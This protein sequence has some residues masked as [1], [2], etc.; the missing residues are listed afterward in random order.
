MGGGASLN[1]ENLRRLRGYAKNSIKASKAFFERYARPA[2]TILITAILWHFLGVDKYVNDVYLT[3]RAVAI[4]RPVP[5]R[6]TIFDIAGISLASVAF[7]VG[8]FW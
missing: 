8:S 7:P 6:K 3:G 1:R 5:V 4:S 2:D